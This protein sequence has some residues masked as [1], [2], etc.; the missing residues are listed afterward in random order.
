MG[1]SATLKAI[2][3]SICNSKCSSKLY[4]IAEMQLKLYI[5]DEKPVFKLSY[6]KNAL[7]D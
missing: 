4:I 1:L 6:L 7:F 5:Y 2:I 3:N